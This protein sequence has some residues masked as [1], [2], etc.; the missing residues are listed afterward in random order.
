MT[1]RVLF[2]GTPANAAQALRLFGS[3]ARES[4]KAEVVGVLTREDAPQGRK[5]VLTPSPVAAAAEELGLPVIKA[6][7]V[8]GE[9]LESITALRADAAFV[10]AYGAMLRDDALD[11]LPLG[12]FNLHY[13]LLPD[14]RGAAPVQRSIMLGREQ[15]GATLF[16]IDAGLDTGPVMRQAAQTRPEGAT[17]GELLDSLT[18][19]G[20]AEA[21]QFF[22]DLAA[23]PSLAE[24]GQ[25]QPDGTF[26]YAH[27]LTPED[28]LLD[29][30]GPAEQ[31]RLTAL[32]TLPA[33]GPWVQL[34]GQKFK[35]HAVAG[36]SPGNPGDE[37]G[38]VRPADGGIAIQ[39]GDDQLIVTR[40]QPFGKKPMDAADWLRGASSSPSTEL[41]FTS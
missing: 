5:R 39:C 6:G 41:R 28:A 9:T 30:T 26:D 22:A 20:T 34:A 24:R 19:A 7:R 33:P 1:L 15:V 17:A 38:T 11:A 2:A 4:G 10:V 36:T 25:M 18:S 16:R 31:A 3:A 21:V 13:S 32:G 37:P 29:L 14:L 35:I 23:D 40:V 27:K 8:T 12:W